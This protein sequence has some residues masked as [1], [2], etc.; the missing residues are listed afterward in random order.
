M[1][2][3]PGASMAVTRHPTIRDQIANS[4]RRAIADLELKPGQ[5]LIERELTERTGASRP[6]VR[7]AL[8]QLEAEG[9][10]ESRNG[11]GTYVR[12]LSL[13]EARDV[14][15]VRAQL[16]GLAARLF[17]ERADE[18]TRARLAA[19]L[20]ALRTATDASEDHRAILEAQSE[21]YR[22]LFHGAGNPVLDRTIQGLQVRVAQLR[23]LTLGVA[24]RDRASLAEFESLHRAIESGDPDA[25]ERE[26][27]AHVQAAA[28]AMTSAHDLL[29]PS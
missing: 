11:R 17:C 1:E 25:A 28:R 26:A 18:P 3:A 14:Y 13:G 7:E 27:A 29:P 8:R 23:A 10:I 19:A 22:T 2:L 4:L 5:L 9:L 24:G 12:V 6:S 21:F 16:E 20:E 15:E